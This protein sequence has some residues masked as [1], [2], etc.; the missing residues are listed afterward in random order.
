MKTVRIKDISFLEAAG[1]KILDPIEKKDG[2]TELINE[3]KRQRHRVCGQF[4]KT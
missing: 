3:I 2:N 1:K 4:H